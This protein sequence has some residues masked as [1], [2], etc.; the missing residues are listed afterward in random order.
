MHKR[1]IVWFLIAQA[2]TLHCLA[3]D[4]AQATNAAPSTN[5]ATA[6]ATNTNAV[7]LSEI[8]AQ[9]ESD[10]T[11]VQAIEAGLP[12]DKTAESLQD[13]LPVIT[14]EITARLEENSRIL[15]RNRSLDVLRRLSSEWQE[16]RDE[17]AGWNRNL[18]RRAGQL[19]ANNS[20]LEQLE[21][22]WDLTSESRTNLPPEL[23]QKV[24]VLK[25]SI[26]DVRKS[27]AAQQSLILTLETRVT[28]QDARVNQ[29]ISEIENARQEI[30]GHLFVR[31][32]MPIWS[33]GLR[34]NATELAHESRHSLTRQWTALSNYAKRKIW[35]F[36]FHGIVFFCLLAV[37]LWSRRKL[38]QRSQT[39]PG[40][41]H[42]MLVFDVPLATALVLALVASGWIYPQAPRLLWAILGA[43]AL[44]PAN[45]VLRRL[46]TPRLFSV[47]DVLVAFYFFDQLRSVA[48]APE[49]LFR[50][51]FMFEMFVGMVFLVWFIKSGRS[52]AVDAAAPRWSKVFHIAVWIALIALSVAFVTNA[53]GYGSL[54]K[55]LGH[56]TLTSAYLALILYAFVCIAEGLI[57]SLLSLRPLA[58]LQI[59]R[60]HGAYIQSRIVQ[61]IAW[62]AICVWILYVLEVLSLRAP[63]FQDIKEVLTA[64]LIVG[65]IKFSLGK[66]LLFA[67]TIW[68]A[69][70]ASRIVRFVLEE[71]VYPHMQLAAGLH[72]SISRMVHYVILL[73][74]FLMAIVLLNFPLTQLT[75]LVSAVGVGL[76]FGLQNIINNFVSGIILLFERPVKVGDV[77]QMDST[78]GVVAHIGIRASIVK[79]SAGPEIIVPNGNLIS[80]PVTNWTFSHR[81][82]QITVAVGVVPGVEAKRVLDILLDA[83]AREPAVLKE[84]P[85]KALMTNFSNSALNFELRVWTDQINKWTEIRSNLSVAIN[86]AFIAQTITIKTS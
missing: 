55:L 57:L 35:R 67:I 34:T 73:A 17:L 3:A 15:S 59:V 36:V 62:A 75:L 44:I 63:V 5:S 58:H 46:I 50:A 30:V 14:E 37:V 2:I 12:T 31:D 38:R 9:A 52:R 7:P 61:I 72:Y 16:M 4:S 32:D 56:A 69:F 76:G 41:K 23:S 65:S 66:I 6:K 22:K 18:A 19:Q 54:S 11:T 20:K 71:E 45:I 79:T 10:S 53:V 42:A 82:R 81:Q 43:A 33:S 78:E 70:I 64:Q 8:P 39:E 77:I 26:A 86:S 51:V 21:K 25:A 80:N 27:V 83:A 24:D 49:L 1:L 85:P 48:A 47:L 40:L 28:D 60:G 13:D 68:A 74:G 84:P 29:S